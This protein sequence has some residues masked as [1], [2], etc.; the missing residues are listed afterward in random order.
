MFSK[1]VLP[2]VVLTAM[3]SPVLAQGFS[4]GDL[5]IDA[6]AYSEGDDIGAVNYSGG[7]EYALNR[8]ISIAG[9]ISSYDFGVLSSSVTNFTLHGIYHM[10]DTTSVGAFV[11]T[12]R[13]DDDDVTLYGLE[14]GYGMGAL[15][16]EG[17]FAMYDDDGGSNVLGASGSY[18]IT[19]NIAAIAN[20]GLADVE[21]D[22][23]SRFSLGAEYGFNAGPSVYAEVGSLSIGDVDDSFVGLGASIEFGSNGGTTFDRRGIFASVIPGF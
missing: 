1:T 9:D 18:Q 15:E 2:V 8:N 11:G 17:Y 23:I 19:N 13:T 4:G 5:R 16:V 21:G 10:N 7:L 22:S 3:A 20:I 14:A 6:Y 12:E